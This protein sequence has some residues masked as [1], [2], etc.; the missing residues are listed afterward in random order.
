LINPRCARA[1]GKGSKALPTDQKPRGNARSAGVGDPKGGLKE[2]SAAERE[3]AAGRPRRRNHQIALSMN[4]V[5]KYSA[6]LAEVKDR[7]KKA[8]FAG[9]SA[10]RRMRYPYH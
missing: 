1:N 10:S 5:T 3:A 7:K 2:R 8:R 6:H 4:E 9:R